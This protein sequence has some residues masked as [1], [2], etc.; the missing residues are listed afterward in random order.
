MEINSNIQHFADVFDL[1]HD[2]VVIINEESHIVFA[3]ASCHRI[4]D[5]EDNALA[6]NPL[7]ILIPSDFHNQHHD[8]IK[9][10]MNYPKP[11]LMSDRSILFGINS[12]GEK[13]P[14]TISISAFFY[15]KKYYFAVIRD[16]A[17]IN[18]QY[19]QEK[20]RAETD[21]LTHL[22]NRNYLS[23]KLVKL[24]EK[25]DQHFA[26]LFIDLDKFKPVNDEF[27][28]EVGD[29]ALQ[30]VAKRLSAVLRSDDVVVRIGGDEFAA[31]LCNISDKTAI[32]QITQKIIHS[33]SRP[34][35]VQQSV[36]SI[37][38]SIGCALY[39]Q[40]GLT[41][42]ELLKKSDNAMYH[43]KSQGTGFNFYEDSYKEDK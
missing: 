15:G 23:N 42:K 1:L 7:S 25:Q 32:K 39:P 35:H 37:S 28:H 34:M 40:D 5:Y 33:I 4:F 17:A 43:A 11:K 13:V 10:Y 20:I 21:S 14:V 9:V 27:G 2:G 36:F 41:E 38:A 3:N 19:E 8:H 12:H 26:V 22:G 18:R 30:I 6:G 29:Q 31:L 16:G 24:S